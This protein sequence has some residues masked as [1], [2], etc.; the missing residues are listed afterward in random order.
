MILELV[1]IFAWGFISGLLLAHLMRK[2]V[3]DTPKMHLSYHKGIISLINDSDSEVICSHSI[4][5]EP[6][7]GITVIQGASAGAGK[8]P[9]GSELSFSIIRPTNNE[10]DNKK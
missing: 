8:M 7:P 2:S 4:V 3:P 9:P 6:E 10:K 5:E 1:F